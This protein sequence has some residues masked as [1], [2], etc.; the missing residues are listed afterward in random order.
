MREKSFRLAVRGISLLIILIVLWA[1]GLLRT[2]RRV[3]Y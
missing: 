1:L 2:G 3:V